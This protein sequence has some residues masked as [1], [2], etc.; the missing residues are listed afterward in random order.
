M[1]VTS[2]D[3]K[4]II[5]KFYT[6]TLKQGGHELLELGAHNALVR[7]SSIS[8]KKF[9]PLGLIERIFKK[10]KSDGTQIRVIAPQTELFDGLYFTFES[11]QND[12]L[13]DLTLTQVVGWREMSLGYDISETETDYLVLMKVEKPRGYH[14]QAYMPKNNFGL[15]RGTQSFDK[16]LVTKNDLEIMCRTT[17]AFKNSG[18]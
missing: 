13:D 15:Q 17:G 2:K 9:P 18:L 14:G 16:S 4:I 3:C 10:C 6:E 7:N 1:K 8:P 11:G 5:Q 12:L